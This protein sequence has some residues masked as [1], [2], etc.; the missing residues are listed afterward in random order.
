MLDAILQILHL[1]C[2]RIK[3]KKLKTQTLHQEFPLLTFLRFLLHKYKLFCLYCSLL[4]I[5]PGTPLL[6]TNLLI[7]LQTDGLIIIKHIQIP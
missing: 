3:L 2:A 1:K 6:V 4:D 7:L 5:T